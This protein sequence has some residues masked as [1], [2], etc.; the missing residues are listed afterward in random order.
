MRLVLHK[1][2]RVPQ[3]T[4]TSKKPKSVQHQTNDPNCSQ[5]QTEYGRKPQGIDTQRSSSNNNTEGRNRY[6]H[7]NQSNQQPRIARFSRR[8]NDCEDQ[9]SYSNP[10]KG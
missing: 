6:R 4:S 2:R 5:H 7:G 1:F 8:R 3:Q 9:A 10:P